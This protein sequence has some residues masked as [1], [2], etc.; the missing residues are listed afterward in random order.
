MWLIRVSLKGVPAMGTKEKILDV[1]LELF[2]QKGYGNVY[3]GQIAEAV[4]IKAPSLY[5][6]FR[7]KREIF[8]AIL[9]EMQRRYQ[10]TAAGLQMNG[11]DAGADGAIFQ[12]V[13]E[14]QLVQMGIGLFRYFLHD[15]YVR[16]FRK[17]LTIEQFADKELGALL[18]KQYVE[19]PIEYQAQIFEMLIAGGLLKGD[20]PKIMAL[21]FYSPIYMLLTWCDRDPKKE[22]E[23][24]GLLESHIKQFNK[25]YGRKKK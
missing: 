1:S 5:K 23:A 9:E 22:K 19:D 17:M 10:E 4:G 15:E 11:Q 8:D 12:K 2:S 25:Q 6:H 16:K 14:E 7:S 3:V 13:S 24:M 21:E 20:D 18:T